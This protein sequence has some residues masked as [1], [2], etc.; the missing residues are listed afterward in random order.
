[1]SGRVLNAKPCPFCAKSVLAVTVVPSLDDH[2]MQ[3]ACVFCG[4]TGP[5]GVI[6]T[7]G[8][9]P[10]ARQQAIDFWNKRREEPK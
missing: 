7:K 5:I 2:F 8:D 10:A 6:S 4:A 9:D 3:V 1:M